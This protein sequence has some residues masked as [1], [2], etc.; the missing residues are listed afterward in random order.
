MCHDSRAAKTVVFKSREAFLF[1]TLEIKMKICA[2]SIIRGP[3]ETWSLPK[4]AE[5]LNKQI[6]EGK[7]Q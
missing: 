6:A 7:I 1:Y 2:H 5:V 3:K 4:G